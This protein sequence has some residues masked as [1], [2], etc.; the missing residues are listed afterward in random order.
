[1][2][3]SHRVFRV[4]KVLGRSFNDVGEGS[5]L[6][7]YGQEA[8]TQSALLCFFSKRGPGASPGDPAMS[9]VLLRETDGNCRSNK[10]KTIG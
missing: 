5:R 4:A 2:S 1:M 10:G 3:S 6:R 9:G 7:R 8:S